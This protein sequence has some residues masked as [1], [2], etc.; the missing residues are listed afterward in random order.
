MKKSVN[1]KGVPTY[2]HGRCSRLDQAHSC[3]ILLSSLS[4]G[5]TALTVSRTDI[6]TVVARV[7]SDLPIWFAYAMNN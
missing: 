3:P 7:L 1:C 5:N 4:T 2:G 6:A